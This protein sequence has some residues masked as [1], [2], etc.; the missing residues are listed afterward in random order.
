MAIRPAVPT[1]IAA[2]ALL[3][4]AAGCSDLSEYRGV[5]DAEIVGSDDPSFVRRGFAPGTRLV[6][7]FDP[8]LA[9]SVD[10]PPGTITTIPPT[11]DGVRH[12]DETPLGFI[13]ALQHDQLGL[14][15]FPGGERVANYLFHA[16]SRDPGCDPPSRDAMVSVSLV[17]RE[18][19]EV[20]IFAG[21]GA[22]AACDL[23]GLWVLTRQ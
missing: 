1:S 18:R 22:D 23:F 10:P 7:D 12:F 6:L 9:R 11:E 2:L 21:T 19:V 16:P 13:Q 4:G 8:G 20:R 17:E 3:A 5:Y 14:Y 15:D